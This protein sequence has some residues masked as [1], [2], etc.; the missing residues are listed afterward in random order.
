MLLLAQLCLSSGRQVRRNH[1]NRGRR[2]RALP[3]QDL[4]SSNT[5]MLLGHQRHHSQKRL[6]GNYSLAHTR[7]KTA[8]TDANATAMKTKR[9]CN[10]KKRR[11]RFSCARFALAFTLEKWRCSKTT[12]TLTKTR[13]RG[14]EHHLEE[15]VERMKRR[16]EGV[17]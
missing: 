14:V 17:E 10:S 13:R 3:R 2:S 16:R 8:G 4:I 7:D 11:C 9:I 1:K 12:Q 5:T 15:T 6:H